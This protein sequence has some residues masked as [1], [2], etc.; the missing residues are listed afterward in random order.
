M[1]WFDLQKTM[2]I[3]LK[4]FIN[5]FKSSPQIAEHDKY[6]YDS[7]VWDQNTLAERLKLLKDGTGKKIVYVYPIPEPIGFRHRV[8]NQVNVINQIK[9]YIA[10]Y[11]FTDK[12]NELQDNLSTILENADVLILCRLALGRSVS[13]LISQAKR[14]GIKLI[15]DIDD[16]IFEPDI[17]L[18]LFEQIGIDHNGWQE[19]INRVG[20]NSLIAKL[21]DGFITTNDFLADKI[22][23]KYDKPI[24][25]FPN[26]VAREQ[27]D[28]SDKLLSEKKGGIFKIGY[29]SGSKSHDQDFALIE[30]E[31]HEFMQ[32]H[33]NVVL[34]IGGHLS[35]S[36]M[37]SDLTSR[38]EY[39]RMVN[40]LEL[41]KAIARCDVNLIPLVENEFTNCKS[42]IKFMEAGLVEVPSIASPTFIYKKIIKNKRNGLLAK[43]G[44]WGKALE[45]LYND[46]KL[47]SQIGANAREYTLTHYYGDNLKRKIKNELQKL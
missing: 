23:Q 12:D 46:S 29:F 5:F 43:K 7:Y 22:K 30:D 6:L 37:F 9:G 4:N 15:Y 13:E 38:I 31:L 33:E 18:E 36:D 8:F 20:Q 26:M 2:K 24:G 35:L 44:E 47:A 34:H 40:Y 27:I 39:Q 25:I 41:Q 3:A 16:Y 21:V 11:F 14:Q 32:K 42:E 28:I 45:K 17:A 19:W 10:T 1:Y